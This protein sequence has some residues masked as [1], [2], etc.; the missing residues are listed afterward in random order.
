MEQEPTASLAYAAIRLYSDHSDESIEIA[1][2]QVQQGAW[3]DAPV[4]WAASST[5]DLG[6]QIPKVRLASRD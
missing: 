2:F 1:E 6:I 3:A 4:S 5:T